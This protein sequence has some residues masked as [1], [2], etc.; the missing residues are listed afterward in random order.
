MGGLDLDAAPDQEALD[1]Y[2]SVV[3]SVA[4]HL[5][6]T[7]ASLAV[8]RGGRPVGTGSA[9]VITP[10]GF[11]LTSAHVVEHGRSGEAVVADGGSARFEVVGADRLSDLA[12]VRVTA[13]D[14]ACALLGD[15]DGLRVGQLVVAIGSPLGFAGSVSVGVVSALGR[16]LPTSTGAATRIVENVIQTDAALH[17]GN[18]GGALA[19]SSAR[20]VGVNTAVVGPF[21]GQG[22]GLA[23][24]V[25]ATTRSIIGTLMA[26]GRVRRAYLG[27]GGGTVPLPPRVAEQVGQGRGVRLV[28]VVAGSPADTAGLRAGDTVVSVDGAAVED[29]GRLQAL[30]TA[31]RIGRPVL[32]QAV[33]DD[34]LINLDVLPGE[35]AD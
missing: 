32:V 23:V 24:P 16:S 14:M 22:L 17:P 18:S 15:A 30:M 9:V 28:S 34:R 7:V 25:N 12:V 4:A 19:D 31:G 27:V 3:T 33:R 20:V 21:I 26:E 13:S 35:L 5:L 11:L 29:V 8:E 1:T 2:S 6:P 10:D